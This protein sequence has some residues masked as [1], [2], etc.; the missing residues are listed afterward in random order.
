MV[1]HIDLV[2]QAEKDEAWKEFKL[3]FDYPEEDEE[4]L[5]LRAFQEMGISWKNFKTT[6]V[7]EY[8]LNPVQP[9]P[10]RKYPFITERVGEQFHA[11]KSTPKSR[12]KSEAYRAL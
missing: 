10:Y 9:T 6:L 5:K 4:R 2:P 7:G 11:A 1:D 12:A 8:V 3:T